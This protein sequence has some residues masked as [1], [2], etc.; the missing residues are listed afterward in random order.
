M[1]DKRILDYDDVVRLMR[2]YYDMGMDALK[3]AVERF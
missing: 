3:R 2:I 1:V